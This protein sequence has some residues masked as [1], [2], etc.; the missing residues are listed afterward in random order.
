MRRGSSGRYRYRRA[1]RGSCDARGVSLGT[2]RVRTMCNAR[3]VEKVRRVISDE[4]S[5]DERI[6]REPHNQEAVVSLRALAGLTIR[7][8]VQ[9]FRSPT[10]AIR[11]S[12]SK[13]QKSIKGTVEL[14]MRCCA[15]RS[16]ANRHHGREVVPGRAHVP[17][18]HL[19]LIIR[20]KT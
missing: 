7:G 6:E 12:V 11:G 19:R 18:Q 14:R 8:G 13:Q 17:R 4:N 20:L 15:V 2:W 3:P 9:F 16:S 5:C 1:C 10:T